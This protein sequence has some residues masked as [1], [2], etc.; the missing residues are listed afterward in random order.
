MRKTGKILKKQIKINN[1]TIQE[2]C[3]V[4]L[5]TDRKMSSSTEENESG[6]SKS[7]FDLFLYPKDQIGIIS[8]LF[9]IDLNRFKFEQKLELIKL[10]SSKLLN[11]EVFLNCFNELTSK[12]SEKKNGIKDCKSKMAEIKS[13]LATEKKL[14]NLVQKMDKLVGEKDEMVKFLNK[15]ARI[16]PIGCDNE[17]NLYWRFECLSNCIILVIY[18]LSNCIILVIYCLSNYI[19]LVIYCL[20]NCIFLVIYCLSNCII[21]VI[22]C[23]SNCIILVIYCL[24]NYII[25]ITF[26]SYPGK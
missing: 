21:L 10:L 5:Q 6:N 12:I 17:Q 8:N 15:C 18:C 23:L 24:F 9:T 3:R 1:F 14:Q 26:L 20:S 13:D 22:Y 25:S 7:I 19:I 4:V 11:L 16:E 2:V